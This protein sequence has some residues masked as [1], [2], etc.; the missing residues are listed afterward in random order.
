MY[1]ALVHYIYCYTD[2]A[3]PHC[4]LADNDFVNELIS[5]SSYQKRANHTQ[6]RYG[7]P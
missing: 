7:T 5:G 4:N 1:S 2:D 3:I 6:T